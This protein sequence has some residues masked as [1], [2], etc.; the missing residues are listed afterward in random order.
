MDKLPEDNAVDRV[1]RWLLVGL[2][3][4]LAGASVHTFL[5]DG[6][7]LHKFITS[8]DVRNRVYDEEFGRMSADYLFG[9]GELDTKRLQEISKPPGQAAEESFALLKKILRYEG[10][11]LAGLLALLGLVLVLEPKAKDH[12]ALVALY[13][14]AGL[15][16]L[17]QA[18]AAKLNGGKGFAEL[19]VSAHATRYALAFLLMGFIGQRFVGEQWKTRSNECLFLLAALACSATFAIHGWEAWN[20][21]ASFLDLVIGSANLIH[22]H[23]G[24]GFVQKLLSCI[25]IMDI[26]MACLVL[27]YPNRELLLWMAIWGLVTALSRPLSIGLGAW[28]E[29]AVR[30]GNFVLPYCMA[31]LLAAGIGGPIWKIFPGS[32]KSQ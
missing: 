30:S 13:L 20:H 32:N 14:A 29:T 28:Y 12:P 10:R 23:L 18:M 24:E 21:K 7:Q 27:L 11:F 2:F 8:K 3:A 6:S 1:R 15:Y 5:F 25:G 31:L 22:L 26:A 16:L 19:M 9:G 17:L 4:T